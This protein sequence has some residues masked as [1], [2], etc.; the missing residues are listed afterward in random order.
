MPCRLI[1]ARVAN[2]D[3]CLDRAGEIII[4]VQHADL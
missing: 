2:H 4:V 1:E 3:P